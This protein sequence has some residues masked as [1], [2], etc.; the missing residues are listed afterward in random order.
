MQLTRLI[1][2]RDSNSY[3]NVLPFVQKVL[4]GKLMNRE[5][6]D[7]SWKAMSEANPGAEDFL[8]EKSIGSATGEVQLGEF[9]EYWGRVKSA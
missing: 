4:L 8:N 7:C 5:Q 3:A 1:G 9:R 6:D 2:H